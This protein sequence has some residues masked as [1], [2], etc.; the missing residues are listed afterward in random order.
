MVV[1]WCKSPNQNSRLV[2]AAD[3]VINTLSE[4]PLYARVDLVRTDA[5]RFALMELE[6]I[7]PSLYFRFDKDSPRKFSEA[8]QNRYAQ[9]VG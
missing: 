9:S 5:D 2:A 1:A 3:K 7:E 6:L 4:M 8:I